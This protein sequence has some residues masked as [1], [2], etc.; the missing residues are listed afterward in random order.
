MCRPVRFQTVRNETPG[1]GEPHTVLLESTLD[2]GAPHD[3]AGRS[4]PDNQALEQLEA[5]LA[6]L[7]AR[8]M[9]EEQ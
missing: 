9:L 2:L 3:G 6:R 4:L 1:V 5:G 7:R 8:H